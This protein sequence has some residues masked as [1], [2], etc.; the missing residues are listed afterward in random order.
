MNNGFA[1]NMIDS[2]KYTFEDNRAI[3]NE[4]E[5]ANGRDEARK[6]ATHD[7]CWAVRAL[8]DNEWRNSPDLPGK[9][10]ARCFGEFL[11]VIAAALYFLHGETESETEVSDASYMLRENLE[12][13]VARC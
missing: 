13:L 10:E 9:T 1:Q 5:I 6:E 2:L 11:G 7:F 4:S 3:F 8:L 12:N